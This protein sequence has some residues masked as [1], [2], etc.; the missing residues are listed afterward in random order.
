MKD[1][2]KR[3]ADADVI[4]EL[5]RRIAEVIKDELRTLD[6]LEYALKN[7][8]I[9]PT[10]AEVERETMT[11]ESMQIDDEALGSERNVSAVKDATRARHS[12]DSTHRCNLCKA[13]FVVDS[14][15]W[16]DTRDTRPRNSARFAPLREQLR[17]ASPICVRHVGLDTDKSS[18]RAA[19]RVIARE[20]K[21]PHELRR[22]REPGR[23]EHCRIPYVKVRIGPS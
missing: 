17:L 2:V 23:R 12:A 14:K 22:L 3:Y 20:I 7:C 21:S 19:L 16:L 13:R 15:P 1:R 4:K 18:A 5:D 8:E 10:N 6:S 9:R 11:S